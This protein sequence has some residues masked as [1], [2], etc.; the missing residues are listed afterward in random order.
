MP[1]NQNCHTAPKRDERDA[2]NARCRAAV[3]NHH[4]QRAE[5]HLKPDSIENGR[6]ITGC[7]W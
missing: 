2:A 7:D 3:E 5:N 6:P 1:I 4:A